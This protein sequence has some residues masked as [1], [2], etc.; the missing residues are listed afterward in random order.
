MSEDKEYSLVCFAVIVDK[1]GTV[2]EGKSQHIRLPKAVSDKVNQGEQFGAAIREYENSVS[3]ESD[4]ELFEIVQELI[5][6]E[7]SF[8]SAIKSAYAEYASKIS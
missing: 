7:K 1:A 2:Y 5:S 3:K 4:P 6:R 8:S